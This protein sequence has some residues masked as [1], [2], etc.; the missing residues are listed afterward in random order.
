MVDKKRNI[1]LISYFFA[2][3]TIVGAKR[4]SY[5][6]S[7]LDN[8]EFR[9]HILTINEKY[10]N[11]KDTSIPFNGI[12]HKTSAYPV[13]TVGK[14]IFAKFKK[15][16]LLILLPLDLF[17]GWIP[18]AII[19]GMKI[20]RKEKFQKILV[21]APPF[22]SFLIG[23]ILSKIFKV[24]LILDYRDPWFI[25]L[26][27]SVIFKKA[28]FGIE[29][30]ILK[31]AT[32]IVFNT[33]KA[34]ELY[35]ESGFGPYVVKKSY[36][37]NNAYLNNHDIEPVYLEKNKKVILYAGN[38]YHERR[39][40]YLFKPLLKLIDN[41]FLDR[42]SFAIHVFGR[43]PAEDYSLAEELNLQNNIFRHD[44]IS[45]DEIK[46]YMKG[47]D[48]LYLP[49]SVL[50]KYSI[51]YKF[52]DYLSVRKPI[53]AI[54]S[55][56]SAIAEIMKEIDCGEV[57]DYS[58]ED[59]VYNSLLKLINKNHKYEFNNIENYSWESAAKKYSKIIATD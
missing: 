34:R 23:Y 16:L 54:T 32:N 7:Y 42:L 15:R 1:L 3:S 26:G 14:S 4:F 47:A 33:N 20:L 48:I 9:V 44:H 45:H 38:L 10:I 51:A 11:Q 52:F 57:A 39:L 21:S 25:D 18:H 13:V 29:K 24:D 56:D 55:K 41:S 58:D 30:K 59:S 49:Q 17:S 50:G 31:G 43:I 2:P 12:I 36:V 19:Q 22:S 6:S 35:L 27:P 8:S 5:L 28:V 53:L 37:I 40:G 46:R